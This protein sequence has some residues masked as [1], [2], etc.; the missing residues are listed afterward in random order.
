MQQ[1]PPSDRNNGNSSQP[2]N[3]SIPEEKIHPG[4]AKQVH[5][6][7]R[8]M[9]GWQSGHQ[10]E[11]GRFIIKETLGKGGFGIAYLA[12]DTKIK[13]D[14][15]IKTLNEKV[16]CEPT[17]ERFKEDFKREAERLGQC[18]H[19]NIVKIHDIFHEGQLPCIVMEYIPGETLARCVERGILKEEDALHYIRQI[20]AALEVVHKNSLVHRDVKPGNIIIR[21][22]TREAVLIDFGIARELHLS[23][24]TAYFSVGYA[25]PE[26][27]I[28]N[29]PKEPYTDVYALAATLYVLLTREHPEPGRNREHQLNNHSQDPL[30][31]PQ[32]INP[33]ISAQTNQAIIKGMAI[34]P[35]YRPQ[36][37]KEWLNL[38][39]LPQKIEPNPPI[40]DVQTKPSPLTSKEINEDSIK[41]T[42]SETKPEIKTNQNLVEVGNKSKTLELLG[43]VGLMGIAIWLLVVTLV[44]LITI[45]TNIGDVF[46]LLF[47]LGLLFIAQYRIPAS[48]PT[49]FL[50]TISIIPTIFL[51]LLLQIIPGF[52]LGILTTLPGFVIGLLTILVGVCA[53]TLMAFLK[54]L[55]E[56]ENE[57]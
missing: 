39:P 41:K 4:L 12:R 42:E 38:L 47:C 13:R 7:E 19:P 34:K 30:K 3:R 16:Q 18:G 23:R 55:S 8:I 56:L 14:V 17:F 31:P 54:Y 10:L 29:A 2:T 22:G 57:T 9:S 44:K 11:N 35:I 40:N 48:E 24:Y 21:E 52:G 37:I 28:E 1:E 36:S 53:S 15:V 49:I 25:S 43:R 33:T 20:G 51:A 45:S 32:E 50:F 5:N 6:Q 26:Q 46:S 27:Y